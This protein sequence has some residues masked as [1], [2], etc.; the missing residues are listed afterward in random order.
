MYERFQSQ[1]NSFL[2]EILFSLLFSFFRYVRTNKFVDLCYQIFLQLE[3]CKDLY[4]I[5]LNNLE[6]TRWR[7]GIHFS[8][9]CVVFE[10]RFSCEIFKRTPCISRPCVYV[11]AW[12]TE[13]HRGKFED[14]VS[15]FSVV[16]FFYWLFFTFFPFSLCFFRSIT[17]IPSL[18]FIGCSITVLK[19]NYREQQRGSC[20]FSLK[21]NFHLSGTLKFCNFFYSIIA[22]MIARKWR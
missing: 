4:D 19:C 1:R 13:H 17:A 5:W 16:L 10:I 6:M 20:K 11:H 3:I 22:S 18:T 14:L 7:R 12:F 15:H 21:G 8:G 2:N 9:K